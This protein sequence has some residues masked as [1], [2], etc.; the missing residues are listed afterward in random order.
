[1]PFD[2]L[3]LSPVAER[4]LRSGG[5][6]DVGEEHRLQDGIRFPPRL[7]DLEEGM[8]RPTTES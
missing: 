8:D 6:D 5:A 1:V 7:L 2:Q 3:L 4:R